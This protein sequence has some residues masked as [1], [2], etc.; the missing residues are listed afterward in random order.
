MSLSKKDI[1]IDIETIQKNN[2]HTSTNLDVSKRVFLTESQPELYDEGMLASRFGLSYSRRDL[3]KVGDIALEAKFGRQGVRVGANEKRPEIESSIKN[4]WKLNTSPIAVYFSSDN[5][6]DFKILEGRTRLGILADLGITGNIVVDVYEHIDPSIDP[7]DFAA[8]C[9]GD[10]VSP[11]KGHTTEES[12]IMIIQN[13]LK[14]GELKSDDTLEAGTA[15]KKLVKDIQSVIKKL[16]LPLKK[17]HAE[18]FAKGSVSNINVQNIVEFTD[19]DPA[20]YAREV[21]GIK[22]TAKVNYLFTSTDEYVA[23]KAALQEYTRMLENGEGHKELR[24]ITSL[25][26]LDPGKGYENHWYLANYCVGEKMEKHLSALMLMTGGNT[27]DCK[28]KIWG[29]IP[30]CHSM[31]DVFPMDKLVRYGKKPS[32]IQ[33]D[34]L[35]QVSA[36]AK[37]KYGSK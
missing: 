8:Y 24:V 21:L 27:I 34:A 6:N 16:S 11:P 15:Y 1:I 36:K 9:N 32:V 23:V 37:Q 7:Q 35:T 13:K 33:R 2:G 18:D 29:T 22:N 17:K 30:Q 3:V 12:A 26:T 14:S 20:K 10:E 4:G 5:T 28:L 19:K 25:E 31:A